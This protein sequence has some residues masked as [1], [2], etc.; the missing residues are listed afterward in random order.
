MFVV[1]TIYAV[2]P[3]IYYLGTNSVIRMIGISKHLVLNMFLSLYYGISV[4]IRIKGL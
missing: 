1:C 3:V 4:N 2:S